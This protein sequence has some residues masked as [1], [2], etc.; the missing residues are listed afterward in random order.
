MEIIEYFSSGN[1]LH[2]REKIKNADW[3]AA[4][5]LAELLGDLPRMEKLMGSGPRVYMLVEGQELVSFAAYTKQDCID[6][7][8]MFPWIGFVFTAPQHRR[9]GCCRRLIEYLCDLAKREGAPHVYIGTGHTGLYERYGFTYL[10]MMTDRWGGGTER[11]YWRE[12]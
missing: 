4:K 12:L 5:L 6:D 9:K 1:R 10:D 8:A 11:V 7:P 3:D 2:W